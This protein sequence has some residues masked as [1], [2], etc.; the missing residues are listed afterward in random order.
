MDSLDIPE[1]EI[2]FHRDVSIKTCPGTAITKEWLLE[3]LKK[4]G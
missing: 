1:E 4:V 3:E 2:Y